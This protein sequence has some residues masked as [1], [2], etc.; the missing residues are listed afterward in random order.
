VAD[1]VETAEEYWLY[2]SLPG[3]VEEDID[4]TIDGQVLIIRGEREAP[5]D[6]RQVVSHLRQ[7]KYGYFERRVEIPGRLESDAIHASYDAGVLT[8][9]ISR[10][11]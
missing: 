4:I 2:L 1:V 7:W 5:F 6:E 3:V 8:V 11:Q 9:R 10:S